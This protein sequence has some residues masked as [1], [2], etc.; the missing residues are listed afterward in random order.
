MEVLMKGF[1]IGACDWALG[2]MA[3]PAAFDVAKQLGLDGL[4][5]SLGTKENNLLMQDPAVQ[6]TYLER[7]RKTGV[8]IA[9]LAIGELNSI[10]YKSDPKAE[11]WVL[12]GID[13][14]QALNI[15][16]V[17]LA[18]FDKGDLR[19]D[20]E[21]IAEV[22]RRLKRA[23][24]KAEK[25]KVMLAVESWLSGWEQADIV[26]KVGSP[27]IKV[28]YDVGNS[29]DQ[30]YDICEEIRFLGRERICEFHAKDYDFIFGR[31]RV[32][33]PAVRAAMD[34]I[35]YRGWIHIEGATPLGMIP[36]YTEDLRYL[37]SV[38]PKSIEENS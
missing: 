8:E 32:N 33:F 10:P 34:D 36:S 28:Y 24:P 30:G 15:N 6:K 3:D 26:Q 18:F 12:D 9:S 31:G 21:G 19:G 11:Q 1:K 2:K 17:L 38:F 27:A 37:R 13:V 23:A 29:H 22:I 35:G 20:S 7:S 4:Q 5:I 25:A 16:V 14:C